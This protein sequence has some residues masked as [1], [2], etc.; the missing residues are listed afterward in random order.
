MSYI[1]MEEILGKLVGFHTVVDDTQATHEAM[2]YIATF[3][4]QRGMHIERFELGGHESLVATTGPGIKT[5][6]VLLAAHLDVLPGADE[7]F[8]LRLEDGKFYGRGTLDMKFAIAAYLRFVDDNR[9]HLAKYDFGI[10]ITSDEEQG[11]FEGIEKL[12]KEGYLPKVCVLP[13]GGDN[14][15]VQ[16]TSKGFFYLKLQSYGTTAHGSRPW[17]G[18]NAIEPLLEAL[19]E[20]RSGFTELGPKTN[21][22]NIGTISGGGGPNQVP[23]YAESLIDIRTT[24]ESE[25][26][27]ILEHV[28][29]VCKAHTISLTV[30]LDGAATHFSLEDP[31]IAPFARHITEVTGVKVHGSHTLGSN[32]TRFFTPYNIPCI[33][34]YPSGAGHHGPDEW[35]SQEAFHQ[36]REVLGRYL[37][38]V[39]RL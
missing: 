22:I 10:M 6:K 13:D 39:A 24:A 3:L 2:D 26:P 11:G 16:L 29:A 4:A 35:L 17:R 38:E 12:L 33:S 25:K 18:V 36:F 19:R 1:I 15:Q 14:W 28:R 5:P 20:I 7:L 23:D 9:E 34:C 32:D 27:A 37:E 8:E 30:I 21:T 31:L